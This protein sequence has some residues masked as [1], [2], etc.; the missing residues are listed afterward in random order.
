ML[1]ASAALAYLQGEP[2]G[3]VVAPRLSEAVMGTANLAEVLA[4]MPGRA[5]AT[6]AEAILLGSGVTMEVVTAADARAAASLHAERPHLS[7]GD[8]LC[9]ALARRLSGEALTADR[10]WGDG[11]GV[12]QIRP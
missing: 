2:G 8:R 3:E 1:D 11:D 6:L 9:L 10:V 12:V 5:E 7:L 4:R